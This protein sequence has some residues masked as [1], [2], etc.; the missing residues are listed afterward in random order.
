MNKKTI[1]SICAAVVAIIIAVGVFATVKNSKS[2][3]EQKTSVPVSSSKVQSNASEAGLSEKSDF[4]AS[5]KQ[6]SE[7]KKNDNLTENT[8]QTTGSP[9][10]KTESKSKNESVTS[11]TKKKKEEPSYSKS[12]VTWLYNSENGVSGAKIILWGSYKIVGNSNG[13]TAYSNIDEN[14]GTLNFTNY[15]FNIVDGSLTSNVQLFDSNDNQSE[16]VFVDEVTTA[17]CCSYEIKDDYVEILVSFNN[18]ICSGNG[19][20][21]FGVEE[22]TFITE[23]GKLNPMREWVKFVEE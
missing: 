21:K 11:A 7:E 13:V 19:E 15:Y 23:D 5:D 14:N 12:K 17:S 6:N 18:M 3:N 1:I 22:G 4:T 10:K 16:A 20:I 2:K 9:E 8:K